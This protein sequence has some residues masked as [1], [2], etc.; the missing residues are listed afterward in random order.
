MNFLCTLQLE[1]E[2]SRKQ[3]FLSNNSP[4]TKTESTKISNSWAQYH[5]TGSYREVKTFLQTL[6]DTK[7]AFAG[8][9]SMGFRIAFTCCCGENT[10]N[11]ARSTSLSSGGFSHGY[12]SWF[13]SGF[14][15]GSGSWFPILR[16]RRLISGNICVATFSCT[17]PGF[18]PDFTFLGLIGSLLAKQTVGPTLALVDFT[19]YSHARSSKVSRQLPSRPCV[20]GG[21]FGSNHLHLGW[22]SGKET[23]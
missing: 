9:C 20:D 13:G 21:G 15:G 23:K 3:C 1:R 18:L 10:F 7:F 11:W 12:G 16:S 8:D 17:S 5:T 6:I 4:L 14:L 19:I 22:R 2:K